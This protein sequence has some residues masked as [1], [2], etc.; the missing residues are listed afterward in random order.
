MTSMPPFPCIEL[1]S[2]VLSCLFLIF[3]VRSE[4]A[5][6]LEITAGAAISGWDQS[7]K[8]DASYLNRSKVTTY[9]RKRYSLIH[10]IT[11]LP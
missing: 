1:L 8:V 3:A 7:S 10:S 5:K 2:R 11:E 4:L 6:S 9:A